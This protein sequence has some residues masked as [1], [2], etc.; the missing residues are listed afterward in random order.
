MLGPNSWH[1]RLVTCQ[2]GMQ[3][4]ARCLDTIH[5]RSQCMTLAIATHRNCL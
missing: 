4:H 5:Y 1:S 2:A 3:T